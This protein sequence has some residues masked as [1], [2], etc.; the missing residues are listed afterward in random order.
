MMENNSDVKQQ[1]NECLE[2]LTK[3]LGAELLGVVF[4]VLI[5]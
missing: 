5:L 1:L 4:M 3:I 2:V